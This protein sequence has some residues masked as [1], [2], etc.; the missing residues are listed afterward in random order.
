MILK[1]I[2][3]SCALLTLAACVG[4]GPE[5][6]P[7]DTDRA[8]QAI[9]DCKATACTRL[10]LDFAQVADFA[11]LNE[12]PHVTALMAS[13]TNLED[14]SQI[15]GMTQL[16]ELHVAST[17]LRDLSGL[18]AFPN[19]TL[20]HANDLRMVTDTSAATQLA[21]LRELAIDPP[22]NGNLSAIGA[23]P[24]LEV[25]Y[26]GNSGG[27][28]DLRGLVG[29]RSLRV[30]SA[31][32]FMFTDDTDLLRI[33]GLQTLSIDHGLVDAE[34]VDQ[35]RRRGVTVDEVAMIVC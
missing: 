30:L 20:L 1:G 15:A 28:V 10:N 13:G 25:L 4:A 24:G 9:A 8:A 7:F 35:L 18:S 2:A 14:L 12:M 23:M 6:D 33:P 31:Q 17:Q 29:S 22:R 27:V 26:L 3:T 19:L 16:T 34:V 11:V 32:G 21:G 5:A